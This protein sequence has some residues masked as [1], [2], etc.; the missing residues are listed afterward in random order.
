MAGLVP[1]IHVFSGAPL[2]KVTATQNGAMVNIEIQGHIT[3]YFSSFWLPSPDHARAI[4]NAINGTGEER[5]PAAPT[6]DAATVAAIGV[7]SKLADNIETA[8]GDHLIDL[9]AMLAARMEPR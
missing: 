4:A 1:A 3:P 8:R 6:S 5:A 9:R 2:M 7:I